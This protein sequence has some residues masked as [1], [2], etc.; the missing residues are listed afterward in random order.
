MNYIKKVKAFLVAVMK[1]SLKVKDSTGSCILVFFDIL[2]CRLRFHV[3]LHEY[4]IYQFY[5]YKD[6]YRKNFLLR[7]HQRNQYRRVNNIK[8]TGSKY[9]FYNNLSE[10]FQ[11]EVLKLP[12]C[13]KKVFLEFVKKHKQ[14]VL[15]P[16]KGSLGNGFSVLNYESDQQVLE[17]YNKITDDMLCEEFINQHKVLSAVNP[18]SVN[19]IRIVSLRKNDGIEIIS[20]SL[21]SGSKTECLVDNMACGGLVASIDIETGIVC[22]FAVDHNQKRY[23]HHPITK[24]QLIGL[25]IPNWFEAIDTVKKAHTKLTGNLVVGWDIAI[26]ETGVDIVEGNSAP[27]HEVMQLAD[28]LPKGE[29]ILPVINNKKNQIYDRHLKL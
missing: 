18:F 11:R 3:T 7:H 24:A 22:S 26:T 20:A 15:K 21:R 29:R 2:Y 19:T 14:V 27:S 4:L 8:I 1:A 25:N 17:Y 10:F 28:L 16:D 12:E 5:N 13:G 6:H 23:M 9:N